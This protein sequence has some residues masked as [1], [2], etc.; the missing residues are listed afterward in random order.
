M[1]T[2]VIEDKKQTRSLAR[3]TNYFQNDIYLSIKKSPR[4]H[5]S[6]WI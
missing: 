4:K 1:T 3:Y 2:Y 6:Q 5:P